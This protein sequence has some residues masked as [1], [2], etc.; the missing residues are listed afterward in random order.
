MRETRA[1]GA[2]IIDPRDAA[3]AVG[4]DAK[5]VLK[6]WWRRRSFDGVRIAHEIAP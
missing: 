3:I 6:A 2:R 1:L 5:R 4:A